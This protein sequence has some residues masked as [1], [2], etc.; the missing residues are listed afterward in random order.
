MPTKTIHAR[1]VKMVERTCLGLT[2]DGY[3]H[4]QFQSEAVGG[5]RFCPQ[6][7]NGP[8]RHTPTVHGCRMTNSSVNHKGRKV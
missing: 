5:S 3:C 7:R 8:D 6:C 2:R 4:R 1:T